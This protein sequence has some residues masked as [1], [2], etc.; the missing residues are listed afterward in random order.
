MSYDWDNANRLT[1]QTDSFATAADNV[2]WG[3]AYNPAS[4]ITSE[5]RSNDA[6]AALAPPN[7][8]TTYSVNG[9]N[10]YTSVDGSGLA[11]DG[12]GNL[13]YDPTTPQFRGHAAIPGTQY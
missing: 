5:T 12:N 1:S 2:A 7:G 8:T 10:R 4:Q 13:T 6:F 3:F 11:Y 9:L